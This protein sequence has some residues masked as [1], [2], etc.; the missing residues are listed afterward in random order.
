MDILKIAGVIFLVL[1]LLL[2]LKNRDTGSPPLLSF[3][4]VTVILGYVIL[5]LKPIADFVEV[6]TTNVHDGD[7]ILKTLLKVGGIGVITHI[8]TMFC[9]EIGEKSLANAMEISADV[10]TLLLVLPMF[11]EIFNMISELLSQV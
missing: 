3:L 1:S 6:L 10:A 8:I 7:L 11:E 2:V 9:N 5:H 4:A